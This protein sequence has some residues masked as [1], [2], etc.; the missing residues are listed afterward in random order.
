MKGYVVRF[1]NGR[2]YTG[3]SYPLGECVHVEYAQ[4]YATAYTA[5]QVCRDMRGAAI[6]SLA[7]AQLE[8]MRVGRVGVVGV[9][10]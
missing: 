3:L 6:Y 9:G 1:G 8:E 10:R 2:Y 4:L 7:L 5:S